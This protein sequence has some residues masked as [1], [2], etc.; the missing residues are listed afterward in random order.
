MKSRNSQSTSA[1][2]TGDWVIH[3]DPVLD[4]FYLY[5]IINQSALSDKNVKDFFRQKDPSIC[6]ATQL[7]PNS[8]LLTHCG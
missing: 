5:Y 8:Y 2:Q 7:F 6:S 4:K 3:P 1:E